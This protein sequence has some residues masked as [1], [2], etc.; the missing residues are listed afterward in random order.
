MT[1][2]LFHRFMYYVRG[3]SRFHVNPIDVRRIINIRYRKRL[4][5]ITDRAFKFTLE[6]EYYEPRSKP[7]TPMPV[8][9]GYF[10]VDPISYA[11]DKPRLMTLRYKS[12][13][14]IKRQIEMVKNLQNILKKLDDKQNEKQ[15]V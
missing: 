1:A 13:Y 6:I 8:I 2:T 15:N 11:Y 7:P 3:W 9:N 12:E 14:Q 10:K 5:C 4:F